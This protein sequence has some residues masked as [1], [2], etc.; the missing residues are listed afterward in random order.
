[1]LKMNGQVVVLSTCK[2]AGGTILRGEGVMSLARAF[3]Q[4]RAHTVVGSLWPVE[5]HD[6][7]QLFERFYRHLGGGASVAAALRAAQRDLIAEGAPVAA[8]AGFVALGDGDLVPLRGGSHRS[9]RRF[10]LW[11]LALAGAVLCALLVVGARRRPRRSRV[12]A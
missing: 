11:S 1:G 5:D 2:S 4:A 9:S 3:F 10:W 6:G 8:W 12:S 7:M